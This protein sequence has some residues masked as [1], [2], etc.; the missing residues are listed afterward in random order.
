MF[1]CVSE[2]RQMFVQF[3]EMDSQNCACGAIS[4]FIE[5]RYVVWTPLVADG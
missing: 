5:I 3:I 1:D 4:N 2:L